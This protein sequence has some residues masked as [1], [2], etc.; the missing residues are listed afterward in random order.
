MPAGTENAES[1]TSPRVVSQA[2]AEAEPAA[3]AAATA[4]TPEA[5]RLS[6]RKR[7]E[8]CDAGA[9]ERCLDQPECHLN[10]EALDAA[11]T[12]VMLPSLSPGVLYVSPINL[13]VVLNKDFNGHYDR[14]GEA[15]RADQVRKD[16][17]IASWLA[18]GE[19]PQMIAVV[20]HGPDTEYQ[21]WQ[22]GRNGI[23]ALCANDHWSLLCWFR[24][25]GKVYH[26]DTVPDCNERRAAETVRLLRKYAVLPAD[27]QHV[28]APRFVP[29]QRGGWECGYYVLLFLA[30]ITSMHS[31]QHLPLAKEQLT[32]AAGGGDQWSVY[33]REPESFRRVLRGALCDVQRQALYERSEADQ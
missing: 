29:A 1:T 26:Y 6:A 27:V 7:L 30:M 25:T 20:V 15:V 28:H 10:D 31:E 5:R 8:L 21:R 2:E 16:L 22:Y 4:Q 19:R 14:L 13:Q 12:C 11:I 9:L 23:D 33:L 32:N 18:N 3:V 24:S 17:N